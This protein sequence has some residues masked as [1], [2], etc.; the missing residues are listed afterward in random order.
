MAS[1]DPMFEDDAVSHDLRHRLPTSR[2]EACRILQE[3]RKENGHFSDN[4]IR[5]MIKMNEEARR[6][7]EETR[8]NLRKVKA[9]FTKKYNKLGFRIMWML[10]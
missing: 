6:E 2:T 7:T 5:E 4:T 10:I 9:K 1:L 3:I 8:L